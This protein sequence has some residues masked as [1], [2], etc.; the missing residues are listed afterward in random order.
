VYLQHLSVGA[1]QA[2]HGQAVQPGAGTY[3]VHALP[4]QY[5]PGEQ[6][7]PHA[8]QF[9]M[10]AVVSTHAPGAPA[11]PGQSVSPPEQPVLWADLH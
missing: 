9:V 4:T 10:S 3:F 11:P 7:F 5:S 6:F 1:V 2:A 8:P